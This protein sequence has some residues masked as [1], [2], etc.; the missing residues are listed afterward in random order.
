MLPLIGVAAVYL[1]HR[2]VPEDLQP[3]PVT[4]AALWLS[5]IV[6]ASAALYYAAAQLRG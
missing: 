2:R 6:M 3:S 4:T 1:R 5:A